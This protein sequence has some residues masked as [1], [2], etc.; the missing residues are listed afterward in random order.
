LRASANGRPLRVVVHG[1]SHFCRKLPGLL[2]DDSWSVR[3]LA[4]RGFTSM[5]AFADDLRR[6]DL[7]YTWGGRIDLG[8]FLWAARCLGKEKLVMLWSGSDVS[9]AKKDLLAG[10][11][12]PWVAEK[13]HWA[14]SPWLAEEVRSLG[15]ACEYVQASFVQP[16]SDPAPLPEKFS[17][18]V[19]LPSLDKA[20]LY[21]WDQIREVARRYRSIEFVVVGLQQQEM[22]QAPPNVVV[23]GWT[24]DLTPYLTRATVLW[25]PVLHDGLSF[26][27]LEALAH[28]RHVL[29]SYPLPGC[30]QVR[31]AAD[32]GAELQRLLDLHCSGTLGLN[33]RGTEVIAR[34]FSPEKVRSE[35]LR[36][37]EG[38]ILSPEKMPVR[39]LTEPSGG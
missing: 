13:V 7:V 25:R 35:I 10:K 2:Q 22:L 18:L 34:D 17:V 31:S 8:K 27:V 14:V 36:R 11:L 16:I 19:Y 29:Y 38:I 32:A 23:H 26:M 1:L 28:G 5:A 6:C 33:Y 30:V 39:N 3:F 4:R 37:W 12:A 15:F 24:A 21:G 9:Y 20:D